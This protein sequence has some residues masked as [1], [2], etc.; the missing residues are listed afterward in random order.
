MLPGAVVVDLSR[1]YDTFNRLNTATAEV[2]GGIKIGPLYGRAWTD[3]KG[4]ETLAFP[5][6]T[7]PGVGLAGLLMGELPRLQGY[8]L[9][10]YFYMAASRPAESQS[11]FSFPMQSQGRH[12]D[13]PSAPRRKTL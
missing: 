6:G 11:C 12:L 13:C 10:P 4:E 8:S 9:A 5:G 1:G 3:T 7:C 2:G